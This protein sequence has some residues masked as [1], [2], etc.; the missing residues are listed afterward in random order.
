ME[1]TGVYWI[2]RSKF[3]K[4]R[5]GDSAVDTR[6]QAPGAGRDRKSDPTDCDGFSACIA[7]DC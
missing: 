5:F 2:A 1:S 3:W 4:R 6:Q 7:A